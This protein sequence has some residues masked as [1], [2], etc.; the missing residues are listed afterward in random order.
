[1]T[2]VFRRLL[3]KHRETRREDHREEAFDDWDEQ[4]ELGEMR[5]RSVVSAATAF[6]LFCFLSCSSFVGSAMQIN[7]RYHLLPD[8]YAPT[9]YRIL[10]ESAEEWDQDEEATEE[11]KT[12]RGETL[13]R[14]TPSF[15]HQLDIEGSGRLR[16][17]RIVNFEV[18]RDGVWFYQLVKNG[19]YGLGESGYKLIPYRTI[20]V[21]PQKIPLGT[22]LYIPALVGLRLPSGEVHDGFCFAHDTGQGI[23]GDRIDIFVGYENDVDNTLTRSRQVRDMRPLQLYQVDEATAR[24]LNEQYREQ[25]EAAE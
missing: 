9:F 12:R 7:N 3:L 14:V 23:L 11:I 6:A 25:F 15:R 20:A 22:V 8:E 5:L 4:R 1:M 16:D 13:A 10:D 24:R 19:Q 21:D 17:G 18:K 2:S